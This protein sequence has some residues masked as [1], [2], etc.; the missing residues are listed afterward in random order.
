MSETIEVILFIS[1]GL[2]IVLDLIFIIC[3]LMIS[4]EEERYGTHDTK[5][6]KNRKR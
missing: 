2:V 6:S 1:A 3:C 4:H 5:S